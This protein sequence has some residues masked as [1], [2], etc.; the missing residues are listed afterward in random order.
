M[1]SLTRFL[2]LL[3]IAWT[4]P[5][6]A[7]QHAL[8]VGIN[9]YKHANKLNK[10]TNLEGAVN[11]A[12]LLRNALREAQVQLPE[13]RVLL[14]AK[15]TSSAFLHA[16]QDM[17]KQAKPGD[18]LIVAFS[19]HGGQQPDT[20]P[21]DEKD[22]KDETLMFHDFNPNHTSKGRITDDELRGLLNKAAPYNIVILFHS[23]N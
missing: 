11:D 19:G 13:R 17:L 5:V 9:Q 20:A 14:N 8:V 21:L 18:T 3:L 23:W 16:W 4:I 6:L 2:L 7:T 12:K 10:L 22:N 15:A 1:T